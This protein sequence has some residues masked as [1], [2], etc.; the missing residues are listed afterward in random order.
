MRLQPL[1]AVVAIE[2]LKKI[3]KVISIRNSNATLM[4]KLLRP[5]YP[6][7]ILP[8]RPKGYLETFALY[9]CL[10]KKRDKLLKYLERNKIEAKIHYPIPLNKQKA[11]RSLGLKQKDFKVANMQAKSIITLPIHQY[12]SK[13]QIK[14]TAQKINNFYSKI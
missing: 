3:K 8:P 5:L 14:F 10:V 11:A 13:K 9:M 4:D 1:Q 6:N 7:V 12:L 2:G